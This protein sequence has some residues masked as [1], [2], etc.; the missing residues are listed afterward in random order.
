[1]SRKN[2]VINIRADDEF[3][4]RLDNFC[5]AVGQT[6]AEALRR[7]AEEYIERHKRA[8]EDMKS[9]KERLN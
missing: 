9:G 3:I 5:D 7:A 4:K 1:M 8:A 6:R 2:R